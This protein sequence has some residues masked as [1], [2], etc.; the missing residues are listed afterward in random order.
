MDKLAYIARRILLII[1]TFIGIT[2]VCFSLTRFLPGGPVEMRLMKMRGM[3]G[4][5]EVAAS[6][7]T[8]GANVTREY[9]QQLEKQFGFEVVRSRSV[10]M[11][12]VFVH[13]TGFNYRFRYLLVNSS[14]NSRTSGS[15][16]FSNLSSSAGTRIS[17]FIR[18]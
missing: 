2:I 18:R 7:H 9:R 5:G 14:P 1:P 12:N 17:C 4:G 3:G 16:R 10:N 6:S 11:D 15:E 13:V 8:A